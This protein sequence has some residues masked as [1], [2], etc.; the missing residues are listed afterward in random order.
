MESSEFQRNEARNSG[1]DVKPGEVFCGDCAD[2]DG[3][4][5]IARLVDG[6]AGA[7]VM[8][9]ASFNLDFCRRSN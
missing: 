1:A 5:D 2:L 3:G 4:V 7:K 9:G 8:R 6:R